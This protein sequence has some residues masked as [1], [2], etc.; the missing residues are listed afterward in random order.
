MHFGSAHP[1]TKK[2]FMSDESVEYDKIWVEQFA[3]EISAFIDGIR[4]VF[5]DSEV[6]DYPIHLER[7][8]FL[9]P[10]DA[11]QDREALGDEIEDEPWPENPVRG[12]EELLRFSLA[13]QLLQP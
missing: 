12:A 1:R 11:E 8:K 9:A 4:R 10:L 5:T 7:T 13:R 3:A 2:T 6:R